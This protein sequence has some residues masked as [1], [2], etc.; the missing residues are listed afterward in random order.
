MSDLDMTMLAQEQSR[1]VLDEHGVKL[2]RAQVGAVLTDGTLQLKRLHNVDDDGVTLAMDEAGVVRLDG[3]RKLVVGDWV[4]CLQASGQT[5]V[6]GDILEGGE[7]FLED[8]PG[9]IDDKIL[10]KQ[11][12]RATIRG[13]DLAFGNAWEVVEPISLRKT[14]AGLVTFEGSVRN[15]TND[16]VTPA[17]RIFTLP[18]LWRPGVSCTFACAGKSGAGTWNTSVKPVR[19]E[20]GT[21]YFNAETDTG[22]GAIIQLAGINYYI[23]GS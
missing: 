22:S 11:G 23:D 21:G 9:Q 10:A 16:T 13:S 8:V 18:N 5:F 17:S 19:F 6:I 4:W 3:A 7:T 20:Y 1:A 12:V 2:F 15:K 14:W